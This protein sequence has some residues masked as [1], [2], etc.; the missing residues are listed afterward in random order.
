MW[1]AATGQPI[2]PPFA[3][4]GAAGYAVFSP[5]GRRIVTASGR[6]ALGRLPCETRVWDADTGR[7][8]TP[9]LAH[10]G[11]V[12]HAAFSP[13]SRLVVTAG[14][15]HMARVWDAA[16]GAPVTPPLPHGTYVWRAAFS[17][18][19][20]RIVTTSYD[21]TARIW[22]LPYDARPTPVLRRL[23][24][25]LAAHQI[26]ASV[27]SMPLPQAV[28]R[29]DWR[30]L[31]ARNAGSLAAPGVRVLAW[32]QR[33]AEESV[34]ARDWPAA[35]RH[36]RAVVRADPARW[37]ERMLHGEAL[38]QLRRWE[39]ADA[40]FA[41]AVARRPR[42]PDLRMRRGVIYAEGGRWSHA[43][44]DFEMATTLGAVGTVWVWNAYAQLAAGDRPG[45][46]RACARLVRRFGRSSDPVP[47]EV[48]LAL[49]LGPEA[50]PKPLQLVRMAEELVTGSP[51][52]EFT[53]TLLT[54]ALYRAGQFDRA[55]R[56]AVATM[57][58]D[59]EG[60]QGIHA[61][62][63]AMAHY[64]LGHRDEARQWLARGVA[65]IAHPS[66]S[67]NMFWIPRLCNE[68]LLREA[69]GLIDAA[70]R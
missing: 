18:D 4:R 33:E 49:V 37:Q 23:A 13:D 32:R 45:Y 40:A 57:D 63:L 15:D 21:R 56:S 27:G 68:L 22:H 54:L 31:K 24:R 1:D 51:E 12:L 69:R 26:D 42:D 35:L 53:L 34:R 20:R 11:D 17:P 6:R 3:H 47:S 29:A 30:D 58:A 48:V 66:V 10:R 50:V 5:D 41:A 8:I 39:E 61:L 70:D 38:A 28:A 19:G 62:L 52:G 64:R 67:R 44:A 65:A 25:L 36:L 16:T 9:P 7:P 14:D 59:S 55:L 46:R 2:G 60:G 43:A